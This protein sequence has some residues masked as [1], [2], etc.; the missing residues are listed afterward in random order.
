M[1]NCLCFIIAD[2]KNAQNDEFHILVGIARLLHLPARQCTSHTA[3]EMVEFLDRE[4][5][6][7]MLTC[8]RYD[9]HFSS[10]NKIK[11]TIKAG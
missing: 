11:F 2:T 7:F 6:D 9:E 3:C 5:L 8:C 10:V 4:M 1:T